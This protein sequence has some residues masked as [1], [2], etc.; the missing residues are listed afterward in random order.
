M[1]T[2]KNSWNWVKNHIEAINFGVVLFVLGFVVWLSVHIMSVE[3]QLRSEN[4]FLRENLIRMEQN[5]G[6][7][8]K[9]INEQEAVIRNQQE[10]IRK[11]IERINNLTALLNGNYT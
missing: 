3:S 8:V 4:Q 7:A 11:L 10:G 5:L 2:I 1:K 9:H 6:G